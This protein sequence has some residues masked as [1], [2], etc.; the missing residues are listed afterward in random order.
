[1]KVTKLLL[2][3]HVLTLVGISSCS[4]TELE[5]PTQESAQLRDELSSALKYHET[6]KQAIKHYKELREVLNA[7]SGA[8]DTRDI[9][10][11]EKLMRLGDHCAQIRDSHNFL[12]SESGFIETLDMLVQ[13]FPHLEAT[14]DA[15][16]F[17]AAAESQCDATLRQV[18]ELKIRFLRAGGATQ[19]VAEEDEV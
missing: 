12:L 4:E 9:R 18:R 7:P 5:R 19:S 10:Y 14:V 6:A 8:S 3:I 17:D 2:A 11:L 1:M 16:T 15:M 13:W